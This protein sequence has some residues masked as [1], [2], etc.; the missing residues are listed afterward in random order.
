MG[1]IFSTQMFRK[2]AQPADIQIGYSKDGSK[3]KCEEQNDFH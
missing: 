3:R 1:P 2:R